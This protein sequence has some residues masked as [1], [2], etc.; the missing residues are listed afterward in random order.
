MQWNETIMKRRVPMAVMALVIGGAVNGVQAATVG[1]IKIDGAIGPA[2]ADYISR[3]IDLSAERKDECLI[4]QLDTPGGLLDS[5]KVI[6]Q[7]FYA[8]PVP[9]VVY[10]APAGA[11]AGSAGTFITM[12][13]DIA[14][15]APHTRIGA[16]HPVS[17]GMG[18]GGRQNRRRDEGE[19]GERRRW[20]HRNDRER[21]ASETSSGPGL[22]WSRVLSST[23]KK[24]SN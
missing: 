9:T 10:V 24:P 2:T 19:N 11:S 8:S 7:K 4:I 21:S 6:V 15:M 20:L 13:A 3:A 22:R 14:A 12:A 1:L 17:I 18:G 23:P 16:A 5:T